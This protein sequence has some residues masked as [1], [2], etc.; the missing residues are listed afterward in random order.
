MNLWWKIGIVA[1]ILLWWA[2][3]GYAIWRAN[4]YPK[5]R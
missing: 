5:K 1:V 2:I 3:C 4:E